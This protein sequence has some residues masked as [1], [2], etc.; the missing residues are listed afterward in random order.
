MQFGKGIAFLE[1]WKLGEVFHHFQVFSTWQCWDVDSSYKPEYPSPTGARK[2]KGV[3]S[4]I[5]TQ[6][7]AK[8]FSL[9]KC[10]VMY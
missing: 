8:E 6:Q 10:S 7:E 4:I 2:L 9:S 5:P 3:G 1:I